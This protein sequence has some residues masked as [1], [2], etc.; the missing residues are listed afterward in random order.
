MGLPLR[1]CMSACYTCLQQVC[2]CCVYTAACMKSRE[3][4][5][6]MGECVWECVWG[7]CVSRAAMQGLGENYM[8]QAATSFAHSQNT[9]TGTHTH[10]FR[11]K[12]SHWQSTKDQDMSTFT[13]C[14]SFYTPPTPSLCFILFLL[15][16]AATLNS[17]Q[18]N[19][20]Y[21]TIISCKKL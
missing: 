17:P 1:Q 7:V 14:L 12:C 13:K 5:R 10:G 8:S 11:N 18:W 21:I 6:G 2:V 20:H 19:Y 4:G 3:Q 15:P 16:L 9:H